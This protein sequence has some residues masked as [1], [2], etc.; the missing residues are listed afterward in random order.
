MTRSAS[1]YTGTEEK[2]Q[3]VRKRSIDVDLVAGDQKADKE[4]IRK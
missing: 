4:L 1:P 2:R 3:N